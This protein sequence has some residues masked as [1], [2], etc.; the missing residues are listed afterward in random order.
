LNVHADPLEPFVSA[1]AITFREMAGIE[2]ATRGKHREAADNAP[3]EIKAV[4]RL[5][6]EIEGCVMLSLSLQ[7]AEALTRK[8]LEVV[9]AEPQT[10]LVRDCMGEL[11]NV[12]TGQAKTLLFGTPRHFTLG[13]PVTSMGLA[14]TPAGERWVLKFASEVGDFRLHVWLPGIG[15]VGDGRNSQ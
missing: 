2:V 7:T 9:T 11:V 3:D 10:D 1:V 14:E 12:I 13:T 6:S 15:E 8:T 4:L 5:M